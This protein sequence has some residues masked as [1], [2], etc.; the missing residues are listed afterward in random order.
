[1]EHK[2]LWMQPDVSFNIGLQHTL[3]EVHSLCFQLVPM[4]FWHS[5]DMA[6]SLS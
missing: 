5:V 3:V 4:C 6:F 1:M 2:H